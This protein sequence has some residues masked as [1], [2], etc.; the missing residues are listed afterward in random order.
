MKKILLILLIIPSMIFMQGKINGFAIFDYKGSTQQFDVDRAY[1]IYSKDISDDLFFKYILDVGRDSDSDGDT[2]LSAYLKNVY[3]DWKCKEFGKFSIGLISTNSFGIQE[4]TWG[5]R[6]LSKSPID[7]AGMTKTA[8]F[9]VG[10][11]K[12]FEKFDINFQVVNGEGYKA[13]FD[14]GNTNDDKPAAYLRLMYG[15]KKLN[16]NDGFNVGLV[17]RTRYYNDEYADNVIGLFGGWAG[18]NFRLGAEYNQQDLDGS[19]ET[20]TSLYANYNI[21]NKIDLF[22]RHDMNDE[23]IDDSWNDGND[24]LDMASNTM[25]GMVWN[26]TK[27]LYISPNVIISQAGDDSEASNEYRLT[28]ML[29]Y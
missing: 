3:V 1:L 9:G 29:K 10:Y 7:I 6:F 21:N 26:P 27:G 19:V 4:K 13:N 15:E 18:S 24:G 2:K 23:N 22:L 16:K 11:S 20:M 8:D 17:Y 12:S 25:L 14:S 5:Y 28:F